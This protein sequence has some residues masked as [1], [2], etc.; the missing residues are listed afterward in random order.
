[1]VKTLMTMLVVGLGVSSPMS[2]PDGSV[3]DVIDREMAASGAPGLAYAV[4]TDGNIT[5]AGARG[6]VE[7]GGDEEVTPDTPFLTGS[8]S[9]SF[10]ALSVMQ[11]VEA[12][13]VDLD[14]AVHGYLDG[15]T[16]NRAVRPASAASPFYGLGWFVDSNDGTVWHSG[17][18]PGFE[19]LATMRPS[20]NRAVVV[21]VN[22][23]SGV[24]FGETT[25]LRNAITARAL[26]LAYDGEGSRLSQKALFIA[27]VL[28]PGVHTLSM[29]WAWRHRADLRAK[30]APSAASAS[31][32]R[33]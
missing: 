19:T 17:S 18:S 32:S 22:P 25:Q 4:V 12:G 15:F 21:L 6:V 8:I 26:G 31:G 14:A 3:D 5:S 33:C 11:L 13:R 7:V 2:A 29:V 16:S 28:L 10:T 1:M 20:E 23:G 9:K 27:L 24:G 30:R